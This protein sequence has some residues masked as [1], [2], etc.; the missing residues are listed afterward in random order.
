[1]TGPIALE[2]T[3]ARSRVDDDLFIEASGLPPG[4]Q[5]RLDVEVRDGAQVPWRSSVTYIS[6]AEGRIDPFRMAPLP[7]G[8]YRELYALGPLWSVTSRSGDFFVKTKPTPLTYT[9]TLRRGHH[10]ITTPALDRV[11]VVRHF[12]DD[13]VHTPVHEGPVLGMLHHLP[14]P[15]NPG[16]L[17][18]GGTEGRTLDH[19]GSL[20]AAQGYTVL[21]QAYFGV[22]DRPAALTDVELDDVDAAIGLLLA[23]EHTRGGEVAIVGASRGAEAALQVAADNAAVGALVAVAPTALRHPGVSP[24]YTDYTQPAWLRDGEPLGFNPASMRVRDWAGFVGRAITRRPLRQVGAFRSQLRDPVKVERARIPVERIRGPLLMISG[25][26]DQLWPSTQ[27]AGMIAARLASEG[28]EGSVRDVR[29]AGV[30]HFAAFPYNIP[31]LPPMLRL[32]PTRAFSVDFGGNAAAH[33]RA[34]W[35]TWDQIRDHLESWADTLPTQP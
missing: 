19:A 16:V 1:M 25:D 20:L 31:T 33:A 29:L 32:R 11:S 6:D 13:V 23:S 14:G 12:G 3:P 28:R 30:G 7:G 34:S 26:E 8:S 17:L 22:E 2:V 27:F 9:F 10:R 18:L 35:S 4:R 24:S 5:V 15:P 21:T